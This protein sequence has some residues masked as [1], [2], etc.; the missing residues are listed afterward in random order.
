MTT[1][2]LDDLAADTGRTIHHEMF[3]ILDF[4][5]PIHFGRDESWHPSHN[6]VNSRW[7]KLNPLGKDAYLEEKDF[8]YDNPGFV[9][10]YA[11]S[12]PKED[13]TCTAGMLM[14]ATSDPELNPEIDEIL[15]KKVARIKEMYKK[16][17]GGAMD[18]RYFEQI[19]KMNDL[20]AQS[21]QE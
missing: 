11:M 8:S 16:A 14:M 9:S 4:A 3:H 20:R 13:R 7:S 18:Q 1:I 21:A 5:Y 2:V 19:F 15:K 12:S 17:S 6:D 10:G